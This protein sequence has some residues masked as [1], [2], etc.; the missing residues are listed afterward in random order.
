VSIKGGD[1]LVNRKEEIK[2]KGFRMSP[3][4]DTNETY[5][6]AVDFSKIKVGVKT[7]NDAV[8]SLGEFKR[9]NPRLGDKQEVLRAINTGNIN[10]MI[11]I[12]NFF[13]KTSGIYARL[14]RYMAYLYKYDWFIT[15]YIKG[16]EGL[17]DPDSGL[18]SMETS[19]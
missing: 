8:I 1:F 11:E 14:C 16:C 15:P 7:L 18:G 13:Y 9:L 12:S 6:P 10:R 2:K 17:L 4:L 5:S 3:S 19:Q